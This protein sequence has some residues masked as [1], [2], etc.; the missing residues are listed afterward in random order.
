M[1][2][3]A[4]LPASPAS[5][6]SPAKPAK[7]PARDIAERTVAYSLR[8]IALY[9]ALEPDGVGRILGQQ[10]LRSGT[11]V[12]ANVHEAQGGQSRPDFIAK[13]SIA[14]KEVRASA[15]WLRLIAEAQL[16][17]PEALVDLE[18]ETN[19]L[20]KILSAILLSSKYGKPESR[21]HPAPAPTLNS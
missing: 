20:T 21:A 8:L 18:D 1:K 5:P 3:P 19:Q 7:P 10:L 6:A 15:Y 17:P 13:L 11:S 2:T 16:V 12:G 14:Y 4:N 9:R